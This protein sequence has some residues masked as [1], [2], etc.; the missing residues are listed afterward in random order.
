[1]S[2]LGGEKREDAFTE[3]VL[4]VLDIVVLIRI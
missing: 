2:T 4:T 3:V 1:M